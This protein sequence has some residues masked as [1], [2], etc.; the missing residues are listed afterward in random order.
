MRILL[1][2][3]GAALLAG[4]A[5]AQEIKVNPGQWETSSTLNLSLTMDGA[6]QQMPP[7]TETSSECWAT[8]ADTVLS[9]DMLALDGCN[10]KNVTGDTY[11][12]AFDM[13][14]NM[15]GI[16]MTGNATI[17]VAPDRNSTEGYIN[18]SA[19]AQGIAINANGKLTGKLTG[20]RVGTCS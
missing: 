7:E 18:L 5:S 16:P 19:N 15:E 3:A 6:T 12:L 8:E 20:K 9:A 11:K 14:C 13:D 17:T 1:A 4:T 10:I 2:A